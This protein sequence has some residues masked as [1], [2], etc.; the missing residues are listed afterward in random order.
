VLPAAISVRESFKLAGLGWR[1]ERHPIYLDRAQMLGNGVGPMDVG[2]FAD[3]AML[4][5]VPDR[6][7]LVRSDVGDVFEV[8]GKGYETLQNDELAD[9]IEN[10]SK[11]GAMQTADT[12]GSLRGGRN[13]FALVPRGEFNAGGSDLVKSYVLF[14]NTHDGS[15]SLVITPTDV[16]VVCANTLAAATKGIRIRHT[17]SLKDRIAEAVAALSKAD[18]EAA[19]F[20]AKV[21]RLARTPMDANDRRVFFLK[22]YERAFGVIPGRPTTA[23]DKARVER[24][25]ETVGAWMA[26]LESARNT[27]TGTEGSVWH[28]LNA[29]TE[30]SDHE[31]RVKGD[32]REARV[33]SNL[34][35]TSAEFKADAFALAMAAAG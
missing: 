32:S 16:R 19:G 28:A 15:G 5:T 3:E 22:V 23:V 26:N 25:T 4:A 34:L 30:W 8:V 14:S 7:A 12:A 13:V 17:A 29:V 24:A 9:L 11:V 1:V 27:G 33:Y 10:L 20:S 31:R 18:V 2:R 35:G 21:Q 6:V